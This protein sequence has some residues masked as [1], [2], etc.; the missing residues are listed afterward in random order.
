MRGGK[1]DYRFVIKGVNV[2]GRVAIFKG[3]VD[4]KER[5]M[6]GVGTGIAGK[7]EGSFRVFV[8]HFEEFVPV[9]TFLYL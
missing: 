3:F 2:D 4:S 6:G 7:R 8:F 5:E 1:D 9:M